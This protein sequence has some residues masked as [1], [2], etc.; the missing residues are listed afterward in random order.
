MYFVCYF[1]DGAVVYSSLKEDIGKAKT[2]D[3]L[4][5]VA[6]VRRF[7]VWHPN[8]CKMIYSYLFYCEG[9]VKT[10]WLSSVVWDVNLSVFCNVCLLQF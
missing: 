9:P 2:C 7:T 4:L 6:R 10:R 3:D 5:A 8:V 1:S